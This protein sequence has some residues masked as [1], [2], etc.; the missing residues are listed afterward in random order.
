MINHNF[1]LIIIVFVIIVL[2]N[3][4]KIE[5]FVPGKACTDIKSKNYKNPISLSP[6]ETTDNCVCDY[7]SNI[8]CSRYFATNYQSP[9]YSDDFKRCFD[10]TAYNFEIN[11]KIKNNNLCQYE[12]N[13][14][15]YFPINTS[16]INSLYDII[17]NPE[18]YLSLH[19][20]DGNI[21]YNNILRS[22]PCIPKRKNRNVKLELYY[23]LFNRNAINLSLS[24]LDP[25]FNLWDSNGKITEE[26]LNAS[27]G[28][29][30]RSY[31]FIEEG[32]DTN[33]DVTGYGIQIPVKSSYEE[34]VN[35][36]SN[37]S[38]DKK[39]HVALAISKNCDKYAIGVGKTKELA[40]DI[41]ILN[42]LLYEPI[43]DENIES[44]QNVNI[45]RSYNRIIYQFKKTKLFSIA[46]YEK[47]KEDI[48]KNINV[49]DDMKLLINYI[50]KINE[51]KENP[52]GI[53]MVNNLRYFKYANDPNILDKCLDKIKD[54]SSNCDPNNKIIN[55]EINCNE[56]VMLKYDNKKQKCSILQN[57]QNAI[58]NYEYDF[59]KTKKLSEINKNIPIKMINSMYMNYGCN[60]PDTQ[61]FIYSINNNRFCKSL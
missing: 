36:F 28:K 22:G 20:E 55:G 18:E 35:T 48:G 56:V 60:N 31:N 19:N 14:V 43:I 3:S 45:D 23:R 32:L 41:A 10:T 1:I 38:D 2:I 26:Q 13:D 49:S 34:I 37:Q 50:D 21:N 58:K 33:I 15:C 9:D 25:M 51:N 30:I 47:T 5:H 44:K 53:L 7:P 54:I 12:N 11:D 39:R 16:N 6:N 24:G 52:I 8:I 42:C 46:E 59:S 61:C 29:I 40:M 17:D 4:N 57:D 27:Y